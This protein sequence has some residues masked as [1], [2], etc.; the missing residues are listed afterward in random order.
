MNEDSQPPQNTQEFVAG[1]QNIVE[2]HV[3]GAHDLPA[4]LLALAAADPGGNVLARHVTRALQIAA[5][6]PG[7]VPTAVQ[8][9]QEAAG[10]ASRPESS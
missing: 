7:S 1:W 10:Q 3:L 4:V 9:L 8:Y 6:P 5:G 2:Q